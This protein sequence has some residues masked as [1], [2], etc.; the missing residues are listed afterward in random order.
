M[1]NIGSG[2]TLKAK[3][4]LD[5]RKL[6]PD[7]HVIHTTV[8]AI[9]EIIVLSSDRPVIEY[10]ERER[11][12]KIYRI[13]RALP[14]PHQYTI[15]RCTDSETT[16]TKL[17]ATTDLYRE[18]QPLGADGWLL[19]HSWLDQAKREQVSCYSSDGQYQHSFAIGHGIGQ[20]CVSTDG[21]VWVGYHD[22]GV[23]KHGGLGLSGMVCFDLNGVP[24]L[25][26]RDLAQQ[27]RLPVIDDCHA[28]NICSDGEV[29]LYYYKAYPLVRLR[30]GQFDR[31]WRN[32]PVTASHGFAVDGETALFGGTYRAHESLFQLT[33]DTYEVKEFRAV[34]SSGN[35][36]S[37]DRAFGRGSQLYLR[38]EHQLHVV[39]W[40]LV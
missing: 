1:Q 21:L 19:R 39:Q 2:D 15:H 30:H 26:Y 20:F 36:I 17:S 7:Q 4:I 16:I 8:G 33:L 9:G 11:R 13:P 23:Y 25:Q 37:F 24:V 35:P 29:W 12:G 6:V 14:G 10:E 22:E 34:D 32:I 38:T 5:T 3:L 27:H 28:I 40:P 18:V 31:I